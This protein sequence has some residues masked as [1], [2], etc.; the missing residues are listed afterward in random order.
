MHSLSVIFAYFLAMEFLI[1]EWDA[2]MGRSQP[3]LECSVILL[4][5]TKTAYI[6]TKHPLMIHRFVS[7][8]SNT[9]RLNE[10]FLKD[11]LD[12]IFCSFQ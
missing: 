3:V 2:N 5:R 6:K 9:G 10:C 4:E 12:V 8:V 11:T 1:F 7:K